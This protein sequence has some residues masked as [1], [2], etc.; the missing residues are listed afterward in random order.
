[1][2]QRNVVS[3]NAII[4]GYAQ[5]DFVEEALE[6]F[7]KI[8]STGVKPITTTFGSVLTACAKMEAL[9]QG[10]VQ[11]G[12]VEKALETFK[13]MHLGGV[14]PNSTTFASILPACA[15]M[16]ALDQGM[17][18]HRSIVERDILSDIVVANALVDMYGKC[19]S[20]HKAC[21]LFDKMPQK[22]CDHMDYNDCRI[23]IKWAC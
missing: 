22:K 13:Q 4:A 21:N 14:K 20:I 10:C 5:N 18:L 15:R 9:E 19:G 7:K 16:G 11:N 2:P 17:G 8:Q 3:W 6:N 12:L 23:C 1:M